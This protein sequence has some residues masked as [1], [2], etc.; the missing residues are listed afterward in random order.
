MILDGIKE[1]EGNGGQRKSVASR[2]NVELQEVGQIMTDRRCF[3]IWRQGKADCIQ[4][5]V[6]HEVSEGCE[7]QE[8]SDQT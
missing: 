7:G 5:F 1:C 4:F 6:Q 2:R 3:Q 8:I